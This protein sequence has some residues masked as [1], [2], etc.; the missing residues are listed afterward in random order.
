M[1]QISLTL[2]L[3]DK[4]QVVILNTGIYHMKYSKISVQQKMKLRKISDDEL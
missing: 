1:W 2:F 4:Y 3:L